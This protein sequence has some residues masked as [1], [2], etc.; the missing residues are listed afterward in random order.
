MI[1]N[2]AIVNVEN[3]GLQVYIY[4]TK[5]HQLLIILKEWYQ[6]SSLSR[7]NLENQSFKC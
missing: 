3:K 2:E 5:R 1:N 4:V 6:S 7:Q